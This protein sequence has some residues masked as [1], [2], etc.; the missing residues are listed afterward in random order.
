MDLH[1]RFMVFIA[2]AVM[3][4]LAAA[5]LVPGVVQAEGDVPE[6]PG[7]GE[8]PEMQEV[9][10][11]ESNVRDAVQALVESGSVLVQEGEAVPLASQAALQV[12]CKP[13]PWF[14][15]ACLGGKCP[16]ETITLALA[17]WVSKA[18]TGF[19]YVEGNYN[20]V[21]E[22]ISLSG[23]DYPTLKGIV[24]DTTTAGAKPIIPGYLD[25]SGFSSGFTLQGLDI[26]YNSSTSPMYLE[27]NSGLFRMID[28]DITSTHVDSTGFHLSNN[29]PVEL[30]RVNAGG[31]ADDGVIID[32]C[33]WNGTAC[34]H[35]GSIKI[36]NSNFNYTQNG[37][38]LQIIA[39]GPVTITGV[40]SSYNSGT[41]ATILSYAPVVIKNSV[42][43]GNKIADPGK[44]YGLY[45][46]PATTGSVTMENVVFANNSN[47][48]AFI[49]TSGNVTFKNVSA[50]VNKIGIMIAATSTGGSG[51]GALNVSVLNGVFHD[52]A[53]T[54]LWV[55]AKG[56]IT[57]TN[58]FSSSPGEYGLRLDNT[59][60]VAAPGVTMKN[61]TLLANGVG[62]G[63]VKSK[64]NI[65]ID[66]INVPSSPLSYG[67]DLDNRGGPGSVTL[68]STL[69]QNYFAGAKFAGLRIQ[70]TRNVL[71]NNVLAESN[72]ACGIEVWAGPNTASVALKNVNANGNGE[73]GVLVS[74]PGAI[75]WTGGG[76][77]KNGLNTSMDTGGAFLA[78]D[79]ALE[80]L[81]KSVTLANLVFSDNDDNVGL[82]IQS[83]GSVTLTN[84]TAD[85]NAWDGIKVTKFPGA[86]SIKATLIHTV[87]NGVIG[88]N[89]WQEPG[90]SRSVNVSLNNIIANHNGSW[91][92]YVETN[93]AI[94]WV[95]GEASD[96]GQSASFTG[97]GASL[98]NNAALETASKP[99]I[100]RDLKIINNLRNNGLSIISRGG[101]TLT[102][103]EAIENLI[104][105][106]FIYKYTGIGN[107]LLTNVSA[108]GNQYGIDITATSTVHRYNNVTLINVSASNNN[109]FGI[110]VGANGNITWAGGM[111][112]NN[113]QTMV[114]NNVVLQNYDHISPAAPFGVK[115]SNVTINNPEG[116]GLYVSSYGAVT[117]SGVTA[118]DHMDYNVYLYTCGGSSYTTCT[119]PYPAPVTVLKSTFTGSYGSTG[120]AGLMIR[121]SGAVTLS[122]VIGNNNSGKGVYINNR[123]STLL[124]KPVT[125]TSSTFNN[126]STGAIVESDGGIILNSI[127]ASMNR[128]YQGLNAYNYTS[129]STPSITISGVNNFNAN[130][131]TGLD[132]RSKG[133]I[134][135]SGVRASN[136]EDKGIYLES[137]HSWVSLSSSLVDGN[138]YTGVYIN[139]AGNV[140]VNTLNSFYNG[141]WAGA[142]GL[143]VEAK[144]LSG[145]PPFVTISNSNFLGNYNTGL[146]ILVN[147]PKGAHYKLINVTS[148]GNMLAN[149]VVDE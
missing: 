148:I 120:Y 43:S 86:G 41:G 42:F 138:K 101:V 30:L 123:V 111:V 79:S 131:T 2:L 109:S 25:V 91:G 19:I 38:A 63:V 12:L 26:R 58:I 71:L 31:S 6:F 140:Y 133:T 83:R 126:N 108:N 36:T 76:G 96:N 29:G 94:S 141:W 54:S 16:Y 27:N 8:P 62:G 115:V 84:I 137:T 18:G 132:L 73:W 130:K 149:I 32:T 90:D 81:P 143:T 33:G 118:R 37:T 72:G 20:P 69:F 136:N 114:Q 53:A 144:V 99:V 95:K 49:S 119:N 47:H 1:K 124:A 80:T 74:T 34:G 128:T 142:N 98:I 139:S 89:I 145:T 127:T 40:S 117:L 77:L 51:A 13:D 68:N 87:E 10:P 4:S 125:V 39:N 28:V 88:L 122:G 9:L 105:G 146:Y 67:L 57:L 121:A 70:T 14:Y 21:S 116:Y 134:T 102:N 65:I 46:N 50:S 59:Y 113:S 100:L 106:V 147:S 85:R 24:W 61:I 11:P 78:N 66:S 60:A 129:L 56:T 103:I 5:A 92:V 55:E 23:G 110:V 107:I 15:G 17:N 82:V 45:F 64:G 112:F 75:S 52:N 104:E 3:L 35:T 7:D 22:N 93:G 135:V 44:G 97:G 48:G